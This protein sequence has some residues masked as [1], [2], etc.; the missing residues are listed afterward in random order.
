[1]V[2]IPLSSFPQQIPHITGR[3]N[4]LGSSRQHYHY[5]YFSSAWDPHLNF[6]SP[7]KNMGHILIFFSPETTRANIHIQITLSNKAIHIPVR[8]TY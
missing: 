5:S 7:P 4:I 1:M 8:M 6:W 2:P 3:L